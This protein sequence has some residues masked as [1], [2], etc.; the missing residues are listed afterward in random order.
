MGFTDYFGH[1]EPK[2]ASLLRIW[3]RWFIIVTAHTYCMKEIYVTRLDQTVEFT[4]QFYP[5]VT[6]MLEWSTTNVGL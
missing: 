4:I 2:F 3:R 1:K 6:L 5:K